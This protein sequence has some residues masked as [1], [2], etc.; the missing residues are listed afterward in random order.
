MNYGGDE[1]G[2]EE[3]GDLTV[4]CA[5][6]DALPSKVTYRWTKEGGG[7]PPQNSRTLTISNIQRTQHDGTYKCTA[8]NEMTPTDTGPETGTGSQTVTITVECKYYNFLC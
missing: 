5:A 3:G 4:D 8:S 1:Y 7:F 2:I 6:G